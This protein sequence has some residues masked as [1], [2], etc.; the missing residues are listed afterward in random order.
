MKV[1]LHSTPT[2]GGLL[3]HAMSELIA[4]FRATLAPV[5]RFDRLRN[6]SRRRVLRQHRILLVRQS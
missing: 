2:G 1:E 3:D 6:L 5:I 4:D